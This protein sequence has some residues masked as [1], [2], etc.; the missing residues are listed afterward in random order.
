MIPTRPLEFLDSTYFSTV[1]LPPLDWLL[2]G[3]WVHGDK[4]IAAG[5]TDSL[6]SFILPHLALHIAAGKQ[7]LGFPVPKPRSVLYVD[8]EMNKIELTRRINRLMLGAGLQWP[9]PFAAINKQGMRLSIPHCARLLQEAQQ[10]GL[11]PDIIILDTL[12]RVLVG[13]ENSA[14]SIADMWRVCN[15]LGTEGKPRTIVLV[16]H[17]TKPYEGPGKPRSD[18]WRTRG[19]GDI[20]GGTDSQVGISRNRDKESTTDSVSQVSLNKMRARKPQP[21]FEL[22][23]R[24]VDPRDDDSPLL[25]ERLDV[26]NLGP[27]KEYPPPP[28]GNPF[29]IPI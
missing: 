6:K 4:A 14:A 27:R 8:E 28:R 23:L 10:R 16:H 26:A 25:L 11:D 17:L 13:D 5:E 21:P 15:F 18:F 1:K 20:L 29:T 7:W 2:E 12:A 24:S 9:L 3:V 22:R 19:S